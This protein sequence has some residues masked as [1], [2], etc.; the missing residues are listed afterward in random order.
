M[1]AAVYLILIFITAS[2]YTLNNRALQG[3][4]E[5]LDSSQG[6]EEA[7]DI[8]RHYRTVTYLMLTAMIISIVAFL[9]CGIRYATRMN[10]FSRGGQ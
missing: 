2:F 10:I 7:Q 4:E 5:L 8:L 6:N 9:L 3:A 1:Q